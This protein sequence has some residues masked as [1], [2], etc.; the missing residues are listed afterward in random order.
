MPVQKCLI[1]IYFRRDLSGCIVLEQE[2]K[3]MYI[4]CEICMYVLSH[5]VYCLGLFKDCEMA[6]GVNF[7]LII[8]SIVHD[9]TDI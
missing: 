1:P 4:L 7:S 3:I 2:S 9:I 5:K 6:V 8:L